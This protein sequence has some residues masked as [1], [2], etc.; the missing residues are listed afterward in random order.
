MSQWRFYEW[1]ILF[2]FCNQLW[3]IANVNN[4]RISTLFEYLFIDI[5]NLEI[6]P[7]VSRDSRDLM[8]AY[9]W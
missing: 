9:I 4:I 2:G 6:K 7:R 5:G 1:F 3:G 8:V